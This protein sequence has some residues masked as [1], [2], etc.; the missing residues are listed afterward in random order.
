MHPHGLNADY[1]EIDPTD[2]T[3]LDK[4]KADFLSSGLK[5]Y[6]GLVQQI[7]QQYAGT[8]VGATESIM[9]PLAS[10]LG[11][12]L[13]SP[14]G[15]MQAMSEGSDPT[16][17]DKAT[18]SARTPSASRSS[19]E[20]RFTSIIGAPQVPLSV[21]RQQFAERWQARIAEMASP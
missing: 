17:S 21:Q 5:Q 6:N 10:A 20:F 18:F 11:L 7:K 15:F 19:C 16:S 13:I 12:N 1:K 8:P 2:A 3:D 4:Q 14:A 9:V